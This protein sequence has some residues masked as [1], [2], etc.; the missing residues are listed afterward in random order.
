MAW[1]RLHD[2]AMQNMKIANLS[3]SAFRLWIRGLCYCQ[4]AL[5]DGLIPHS[6]LRDM[7]ARRKDV[8]ELAAPQVAGHTPLWER[9]DQFGFKVHDYLDWNDSREKVNDRKARQ[10]ERKE[11]WK[12][13]VTERV[14]D[15]VPP[16]VP[17][18]S[19]G[20]GLVNSSDLSIT[21]T[22]EGESEGKPV[23]PK[24][25]GRQSGRIFLHRWQLDAL[26]DTLGPHAVDFALDEWL[27]ALS[28]RAG[29][30]PKDRWT[31]VQAELDAEVRRRGLPVATAEPA[32][33]TNKRIAGL[34][35]GGEAFLRRVAEQKARESA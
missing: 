26:I 27:D 14:P 11:R 2:G 8:D 28:Q 3:D 15:D 25:S 31:W 24:S 9:I 19:S 23:R 20:F 35:A 5:T 1:V 34:M 12:E 4:T 22:P 7:G 29:V 30:L 10:R 33:P 18:A 17:S 6:A 32:A 21:K 13:R 16:R